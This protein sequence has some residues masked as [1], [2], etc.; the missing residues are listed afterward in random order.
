MSYWEIHAL[1]SMFSGAIRKT[2]SVTNHN[3]CA[4]YHQH[5]IG[6]GIG[7]RWHVIYDR[8]N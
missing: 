3:H 1:R 6:D 8:R 2:Q 5:P 4:K 7:K